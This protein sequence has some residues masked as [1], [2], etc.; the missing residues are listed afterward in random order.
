MSHPTE[1]DSSQI[2]ARCKALIGRPAFDAAML[3]VIL[4]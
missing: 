1:N 2:V 4:Y 3:G